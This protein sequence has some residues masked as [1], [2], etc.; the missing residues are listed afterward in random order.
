MST[1]RWRRL[2][3]LVIT[4]V[5]LGGL[6]V[7][8][9]QQ[10]TVRKQLE[11]SLNNK[12]YRSFYD[13]LDNVQSVE[14]LLS[15]VLIAQA[16][17]QD[18]KI[19][20][21]IWQ[22]ANAAQANLNQLPLYD[23]TTGRTS[24]FLTQV[25]D[26]SFTLL[27][28]ISAGQSKNQ[29]DWNTLQTLY[30]QTSTLNTELQDTERKI[31]EG[32]LYL[33]ELAQQSGRVV[34]KEGPKL[35]NGNFQKIEDNLKNFPTLIYDGPF[36]D[37]LEERTARGI[38]GE[39]IN[40]FQAKDRVL[41]LVEHR[42]G[43]KYM[44]EGIR[45][46][47][48][49]IPAFQADL[50]STSGSSGEKERL[51]VAVSRQGG[52]LLWYTLSRKV[53][54][55]KITLAEAREKAVKF[56]SDKGYKNMTPIYYEQGAG[57]VVFNF[58]ATQNG[59]ILYPDQIKV[60]VALDNGQ[61]LGIEATNYLITHH[62]RIIPK[63]GLTLAQAREKLSPHLTKISSGRLALIPRGTA[64]EVLT[65]EFRGELNQDTFLIYINAAN[66]KEEQVLRLVRNKEG[67]LSF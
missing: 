30:K 59:V 27:Q 43:T 46:I 20:S 65:Y 61:I 19:F 13:L 34:Q 8:G 5:L 51:G 54:S 57:M 56:L 63:P 22:R 49:K 39:K 66:G 21:E 58:A 12:Y 11:V 42:P 14:V 24:K 23:V 2:L 64:S 50:I 4:V 31:A 41:G 32:K 60:T 9:Y 55:N 25:G 52:K 38:T 45:K 17:E 62:R 47:E 15:K 16:P 48:G 35:A 10:Y 29:K 26:Y 37:K 1:I 36:S 33:S 67:I 18:S 3:P 40:V 6:F 7:W 44:M 53:A 28:K